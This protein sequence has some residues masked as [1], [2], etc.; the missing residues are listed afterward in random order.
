MAYQLYRNT[1]LGNSLQESLG[2]F[3]QS[4]QITPQLALQVLL[5]FDKAINSALAQR[6]RNRVHFK[7]SLNTYRFCNNVWTFVLNDVEFREVTELI[8]VDK[9]KIVACDG[10]NTG[11]N[12]TE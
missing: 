12:T 4:Q 5:Q 1:M 10:K 11:S 8:K 6:V 3:I 7:G 9:V 2:E